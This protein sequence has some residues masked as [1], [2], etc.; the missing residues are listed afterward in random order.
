MT[1]F[2]G[3]TTGTWTID[4]V[5]SEFAFVA[6]HA[7]VSKV[8]GIFTDF[9]GTL[10]VAED[11]AD[12]SVTATAEVV[13]VDTRN[14]QRDGHLKTGD[15][16]SAEEFPQL[17]FTSTAIR[18]IDG[19]NFALVGELTMRGVT[20]E[21]VFDAEFNGATTDPNGNQ[22][23]GFSAAT[24]VNRKDYGMAFEVVLGGGDL[25]VS[26]KVKIELELEFVKA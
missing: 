3:L 14:E 18:D 17:T 12:S 6:R 10:E 22:V 19:E 7:G 8:R 20:K 9:E 13:S 16:F 1:Q 23:A 2:P 4:P 25:L 11:F 15:F 24:T 26:D 21:V 5:H